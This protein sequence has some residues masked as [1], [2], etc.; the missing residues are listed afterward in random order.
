MQ[1]RQVGNILVEQ[2]VDGNEGIDRL[3]ILSGSQT[4]NDLI[5][6][7]P[8]NQ[9]LCLAFY[10]CNSLLKVISLPH[11]PRPWTPDAEGAITILP[12]LV[13]ISSRT[14]V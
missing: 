3:Y 14:G 4:C 2:I 12:I 7:E 1:R 6:C 10:V 8:R 9:V 5:A 13:Y 11:S